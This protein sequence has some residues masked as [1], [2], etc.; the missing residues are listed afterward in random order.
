MQGTIADISVSDAE[1]IV[2]KVDY[3]AMQDGPLFRLIFPSRATT[4][5][6]KNEIIQWYA[7]G[8]EDALRRKGNKL[9][10]ICALDGTPL[11]FCGWTVEH[12]GQS[13]QVPMNS[14]LSQHGTKL[15][16]LPEALDL[17]AWLSVSSDLRSERERILSGWDDVCLHPDHQRHGLGSALLKRVCDDIDELGWPAFVMSSPAGVRLYTKFGFDVVSRIET[18]EGTLTSMFRRPRILCGHTLMTE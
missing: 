18:C 8:L 11:G 6:Q 3:P 16:S 14:S 17:S 9:L 5:A 4:E 13:R 10:Q 2:R 7:E 12:R 1:R 15:L